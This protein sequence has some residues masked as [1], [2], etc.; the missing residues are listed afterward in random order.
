MLTNARTFSILS[1]L[2][3]VVAVD[4]WRLHILPWGS[5]ATGYVAFFSFFLA[6]IAAISTLAIVIA[7][8]RSAAGWSVL[9]ALVA[10]ICLIVLLVL[11][12]ACPGGC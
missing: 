12:V 11:V 9:P 10:A 8:G 3:T 5:E 6:V 2:L 1:V 7:R 4:S